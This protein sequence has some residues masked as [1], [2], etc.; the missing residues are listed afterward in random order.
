MASHHAGCLQD[1]VLGQWPHLPSTVEPSV[2]WAQRPEEEEP[3]PPVIPGS[4]QPADQQPRERPSPPVLTKG[5]WSSDGAGSGPQGVE[6]QGNT[7]RTCCG[8]SGVQAFPQGYRCIFHLLPHQAKW[9][10]RP[11]G[12]PFPP[13]RSPFNCQCTGSDP[14]HWCPEA[15]LLLVC[16][17]ERPRLVPGH[18]QGET[19]ME[20]SWRSPS[21]H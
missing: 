9:G 1:H 18:H 4:D 5:A 15:I 19:P 14:L 11:E 13:A 3:C 8:E 6:G 10:A 16:P 2:S 21:H 17:F 7:I 12:C 20:K